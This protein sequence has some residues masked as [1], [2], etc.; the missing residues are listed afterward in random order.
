MIVA[1]SGLQTQHIV[2]FLADKHNIW[3]LYGQDKNKKID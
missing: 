2:L 3:R 1:L